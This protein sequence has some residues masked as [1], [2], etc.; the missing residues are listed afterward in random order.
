MTHKTTNK[1]QPELCTHAVRMV[2]DYE[3]GHPSRWQGIRVRP[4][5]RALTG[6]IWP[7]KNRTATKEATDDRRPG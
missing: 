5:M 4:A 1:L 3:V 7:R 6:S 2:L